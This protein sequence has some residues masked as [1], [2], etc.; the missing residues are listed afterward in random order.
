MDIFISHIGSGT[1]Q[2]QL[3]IELAHVFHDYT[4]ASL[5]SGPSPMN[6]S[7]VIFRR[8]NGPTRNGILTVPTSVIGERFLQDFG[9]PLPRRTVP[10][11][12]LTI[13]FARGRRAPRPNVLEDIRRTPYVDPREEEDRRRLTS[14]LQS[15]A[16][17]LRTVQFGWECR[18]NVFSVEWEKICTEPCK[19]VFYKERREFRI[20]LTLPDR[21]FILVI[22][23]SQIN[24][25]SAGVDR[26][27]VPHSSVIFLLLAHPPSFESTPPRPQIGT[28]DSL[29]ELFSTLDIFG[30]PRQDDTRQRWSHFLDDETH[31]LVAPFTSLALRLVCE[32]TSGAHHFRRLCG[33]ATMQPDD[34]LYPV[35]R[36]RLFSPDVQRAYA[37][38][39][40]LLP[41]PV[42]FQL[43]AMVRAW[44][45]DMRETV[46]LRPK[47]HELIREKGGAYTA[48]F[49]HHFATRLKT[50]CWYTEDSRSAPI[51]VDDVFDR[52]R[53]DYVPV[54]GRRARRRG[55]V[56]LDTFQCLHVTVTPTSHR[57]EG[58]YP[59]RS[60]RIMRLYPQNHDSFLR[61]NFVDETALQYRFDREVDGRTFIKRRVG[62]ILKEGI[63]IAGRHFD[64]LAYSQSALKEHAVWFVRQFTD[65]EGNIVNASTIIA[66]LGNF[67]NLAHDR[68]L[69]YCPARY[70]ARISQAFTA[71]DS[72]VTVEAEEVIVADDIKDSTGRW[73]FTDG[74]GTISPDLAREIW[75]VQ[76]ARRRG[77]R[78]S[79]TYARALQIRFM[80]SKGMLSVDYRLTGRQV[81]LR[82][83]MIKFDAPNS[84]DIEIARAFH[85]PGPFYLNRPLIMILEA[86][87]VGRDVFMRLQNIAVSQAQSSV[88][89]LERAARLMETFGLGT[90]YRL[91]SVMLS[92]HKLGVGPLSE[93]PFWTRMMDFAINHVLRE[94]K[95]HARIPVPNGWNLVGVADIH[96]YL[97]PGEIF[98]CIIPTDGG[99]PVYLEGPTLVTRSPTIHPG[100][101][102]IAHAIGPPPPGSP[103][104]RETLRNTLVFSTRGSIFYSQCP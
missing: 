80:G 69:I 64:F 92:L 59:E 46:A 23:A 50:E 44:L 10:L 26:T 22:R 54:T 30:R 35:E 103:F 43:E 18:D 27:V 100:D 77:A 47:L 98:A 21:T 42:A 49:L 71:T 63:S 31:S 2:D 75:T 76:S 48:G 97:K 81:L 87:G 57:L 51:S 86:M 12:G 67:H 7:V 16:I 52:C 72:S 29:A 104:E 45:L 13:R 9:Q 62:T 3:K 6:F 94:L 68:Q 14:E 61:V 36:R 91:T 5:Y 1:T 88:E 40:R 15:Q 33:Y 93:D 56:D 37:N 55:P 85:K 89:S 53:R 79:R 4:Y 24:W 8:T 17:P 34:Y 74:I 90:S 39:V 60:N 84:R 58:P 78:R 11:G 73:C 83:S 38:W 102:Q 41:W 99:G 70:G 101:V 82:E 65:H 19:L 32:D 96:G 25:S 95:H 28:A 66:G 20:E